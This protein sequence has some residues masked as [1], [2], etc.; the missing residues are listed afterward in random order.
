MIQS[1]VNRHVVVQ[2]V[3]EEIYNP[4]NVIVPC[5]QGYSLLER[6]CAPWKTYVTLRAAVWVAVA[7]VANVIRN[8][9]P[10]IRALIFYNTMS[11]SERQSYYAVAAAITIIA[12]TA[13]VLK[14]RRRKNTS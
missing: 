5:A 12:I 3:V 7:V 11:P 6:C 2:S 9:K 8:V 4:R 10:G 1:H 13:M 14:K